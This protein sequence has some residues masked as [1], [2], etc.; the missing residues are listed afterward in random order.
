MAKRGRPPT[1]RSQVN[2]AREIQGRIENRREEVGMGLEELARSSG[3]NRRTL[4]AY[5]Q[6]EPKNPSFFLV[7]RLA[8]VLDI[9]LDE[10]AD[11]D[12]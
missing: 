1:P 2:A 11:L 8:R 6:K 9:S 3:V 5:L 4:D 7:A 10:L 12:E